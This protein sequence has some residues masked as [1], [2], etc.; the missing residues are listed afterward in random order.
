MTAHD[1]ALS[2]TKKRRHQSK[3]FARQSAW[4]ATLAVV[5]AGIAHGQTSDW[6]KQGQNQ[7]IYQMD[8][9]GNRIM[10]F[11]AAGYKGGEA[12]PNPSTLFGSSTW[13][14]EN[15]SAPANGADATQLIQAAID[16]VSGYSAWGH[17]YRG[18][19]KLSDGLY[20][21]SN[22]LNINTGGVILLGGGDGYSASNS[23][24]IKSTST[25]QISLIKVESPGVGN[26][27][28]GTGTTANII[29]KVVPAG[30][31]SFRVSNPG[32]FSVGNW[33]NV[34]R[35]PNQAWLNR[36]MDL[37]PNDPSGNNHGWTTADKKYDHKQERKITRIEGDR[38]FINAPLAHSIN[39]EWADGTIRRY[40]DNRIENVGIQGI[41]GTTV[42]DSSETATINGVQTFTD[43]DHAWTFIDIKNSK[44]TWVKDVT[45][46]F[47]AYATVQTGVASRSITVQ[48]AKHYEPAS[49]VIGG[50]RYAF[51]TNGAFVLMEDLVADKARRAFINNTTFNGYNRGPNV[52]LN[53]DADDSFVHSGP[54]A[55][56]STGALY[57]VISDDNGIEARRAYS[58]I[59]HGWRGGNT[60]FWNVNTPEFQIQD[61]PD[62]RNYVI[63]G[64]GGT[65]TTNG[66]D[67]TYEST[68]TLIDFNDSANP[69]NSLYVQQRLEISRNPNVEYREYWLGDFDE[70]DYDGVS[71]NDNV[72]VDSGWLNDINDIN[73]INGMTGW[74]GNLAIADFDQ[75]TANRR[76]PFSFDYDLG[77][78]EDV[79]SA[80]LTIATKRLGSHS[81]G[82]QIYLDSLSNSIVLPTQESWGMMF[83]GNL[84]V[85]QIEITGAGLNDLQD[86]LFNLMVMDDRP[87]DW[88]HLALRVDTGSP[89]SLVPEPASLSL[90]ALG[91]CLTSRRRRSP[92]HA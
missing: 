58:P 21:I 32:A 37:Y 74:A 62:A 50:R 59:V 80:V 28:S 40:N 71:S 10:N 11:A 56:Y 53:G 12:L 77:S 3:R 65:V 84:Q 75:D 43:E 26:S 57:D 83:D 76:V 4:I 51:L 41:R 68:N 1:S 13:R 42:F 23:T 17:G 29:D 6:V 45:S 35:D 81:D 88:A 86:G 9:R 61:A 27:L 19:V 73:D 14:I 18:V 44:N 89:I 47:M 24:V 38:V 36:M 20:N 79:V 25:N 7:L 66:Q 39:S 64:T 52:F 85:V 54:H 82:D 87:V 33:V 91:L 46:K 5:N 16:K 60:V 78:G 30:A 72:Y 67:A 49:Q 34:K 55:G 8:S 69:Q 22:T 92:E 15:V 90:V 2:N 70:L 31:S 63:G 48:D